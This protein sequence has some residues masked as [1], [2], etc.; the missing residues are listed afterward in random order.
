MIPVIATIVVAVFTLS[1]FI[2]L[3][4]IL[5]EMGRAPH[6]SI[7]QSELQKKL[8]K[9]EIVFVVSVGVLIGMLLMMPDTFIP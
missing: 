9:T 4:W 3:A 2:R 7:G 5:D 1:M 6:G 8:H